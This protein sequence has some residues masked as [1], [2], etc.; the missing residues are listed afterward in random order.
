M[1]AAHASRTLT[2]LCFRHRSLSRLARTWPS[3]ILIGRGPRAA[4][5][6]RLI[7]G[8]VRGWGGRKARATRQSEESKSGAPEAAA[9]F[10]LPS[11]PLPPRNYAAGRR[12]ASSF[13]PGRDARCISRAG[14]TLLLMAIC[15]NLRPRLRS[16][17]PELVQIFGGSRGVNCRWAEYRD[18]L[19]G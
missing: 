6:R 4:S 1:L 18:G 12:F 15:I 8:R 7:K 5:K 13:W 16:P 14:A 19:Q 10:A 9:I 2:C 3:R 17:G 11:R